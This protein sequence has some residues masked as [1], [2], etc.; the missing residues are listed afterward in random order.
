MGHSSQE[1]AFVADDHD[2]GAQP[3]H[4]GGPVATAGYE[5]PGGHV[6]GVHKG[7][8]LPAGGPAVPRGHAYAW[9]TEA[10]SAFAT[11]DHD[12]AGQGVHSIEEMAP[13]V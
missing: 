12:P 9:H 10:L 3:G 5:V 8:L 13:G 11:E 1:L 2:P 4:A 7:A 6:Y